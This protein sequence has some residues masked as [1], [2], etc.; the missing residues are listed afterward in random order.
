MTQGQRQNALR[1]LAGAAIRRSALL[2]SLP[3]N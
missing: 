1:V 2:L 3:I